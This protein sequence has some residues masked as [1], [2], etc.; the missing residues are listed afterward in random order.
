[1]KRLDRIDFN[2]KKFEKSVIAK[3]YVRPQLYDQII[4]INLN[5]TSSKTF[6]NIEPP[7]SL[8]FITQTLN[9]LLSDP[10]NTI[11]VT[12][13]TTNKTKSIY[14]GFTQIC[15]VA[16]GITGSKYVQPTEK[17]QNGDYWVTLVVTKPNLSIDTKLELHRHA[18]AP[19]T[20]SPR[21]KPSRGENKP[22]YRL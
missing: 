20:D 18:R 10:G 12:D 9:A 4:A 21:H 8:E 19:L 3:G 15:S 17:E 5:I 6:S 22:Y 1:M 2:S 16:F 14:Y 13:T 7:P 11:T